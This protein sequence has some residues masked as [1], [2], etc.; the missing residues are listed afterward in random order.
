MEYGRKKGSIAVLIGTRPEG[1]KLCPLILRMHTC[2]LDPCVIRSGQH[3]EM[4]D[5][6]LSSFAVSADIFFACDVFRRGSFVPAFAFDCIH[7]QGF[8]KPCASACDRSGRYGNR[9]CRRA[10]GLPPAHSDFARGGRLA[11]GRSVFSFS[12][13]K[14]PKKHCL[15]GIPAYCAIAR[16]HD[17]SLA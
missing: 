7:W 6:V 4:L 5:E 3:G 13:G 17:A 8:S 14:L 16:G 12:R 11:L 15:H 2:G 1:I 9:L 10:R